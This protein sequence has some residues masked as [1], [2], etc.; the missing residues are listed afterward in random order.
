MEDQH[1]LLSGLLFLH[2]GLFQPIQNFSEL[3]PEL[4]TLF[5]VILIGIKF[6]ENPRG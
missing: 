1:Q 4:V 3:F 2:S 6:S 5:R